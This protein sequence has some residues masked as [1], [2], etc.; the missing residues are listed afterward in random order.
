MHHPS[1]CCLRPRSSIGRSMFSAI[2]NFASHHPSLSLISSLETRLPSPA[3]STTGLGL[4]SALAPFKLA[5]K[6]ILFLHLRAVWF[7]YAPHY[8]L[9]TGLYIVLHQHW[10]FVSIGLIPSNPWQ[11]IRCCYIKTEA[12]HRFRTGCSWWYASFFHCHHP[13]HLFLQCIRFVRNYWWST[14]K[15]TLDHLCMYI[16]FTN[17]YAQRLTSIFFRNESLLWVSCAC[18]RLRQ[19]TEDS[20][21][22][23]LMI[24]ELKGD[25]RKGSRG[26]LEQWME[27]S[28]G[29]L[30]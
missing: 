12:V 9:L 25:L 8:Q 27:N 3:Q 7:P 6:L 10:C 23:C 28:T 5:L 13:L 30:L 22:R 24:Q 4:L 18:H 26:V 11:S 15:S 17:V 21:P 16:L 29:F 1:R 14:Y 2:L 19:T 20:F